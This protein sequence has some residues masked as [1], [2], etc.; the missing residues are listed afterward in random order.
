[1]ARQDINIGVEGN[2]GTGDSIRE[3]FRKT[4]ENFSELYAVFG[5]GG[6]IELTALSD[7]PDS[8]T[9]QAGKIWA[10]KQD[11]T[12]VEV[13]ELASGSELTGD[14][15]DDTVRFN[16]TVPGKLIIETQN[17]K[18]SD[19]QSPTLAQ[20]MN[21]NNKGIA[22]VAITDAAA[23]AANNRYGGNITIDDLVIDKKYGDE[24]YLAR[25]VPG[26]TANLRSEP[27]DG[28]EYDFIIDSFDGSSVNIPA[29]GLNRSS[30]VAPYVY[31]TTGVAAAPLVNEQ[32]YYIRVVNSEKV[33]LYAD[34]ATAI[35]GTAPIVITSE[36]TGQHSL[37]DGA[38]DSALQGYWLK[39]E[40]LPREAVVR[41]QG[42]AM[43]GA[44]QLHDHPGQFA[45]QGI[46]NGLDDFQAASKYYVDAQSYSSTTNLY[47][48]PQGTDRQELIPPDKQGRSPAFAFKTINAACRKAEEIIEASPFEP[49]PY[50]QIITHSDQNFNSEIT[51]AAIDGIL[52]GRENVRD[53]IN[54]NKEFL[55]AEVM[56]FI[57]VNYPD[58][59]YNT[60]LCYRDVGLM[61]DSIVLDV[62]TGNNANYLSRWAGIRYY[63][64]PSAQKAITVQRTETIAA[65]EHLK[66][67]TDSIIKS[68]PI[69][70]LQTKFTQ[71]ADAVTYPVDATAAASVEGKFD[72]I[73]DV[74]NDGVLNAPKIVDG[75]LYKIAITNGNQGFVDQ[76]DP[77]NQDL[78]PGKVIRGRTSGA[79]GRII[80]YTFESDTGTVTPLENDT[81]EVVLLE[82]KTFVEGE[83]L[84]YGNTVRS[85]QVTVMIETGVYYED[86]PIKVPANTTIFGDEFR[87]SIIRPKRRTSQSVW[88][89]LYFYRDKQF[90]GLTGTSDSVTGFPD[91]NLPIAGTPYVNPLTDEVDGYF[92]YHYLVDPTRPANVSSLGANNPGKFPQASD[93]LLENKEF[94]IEEVIQY[95]DATYPTLDYDEQK[96]R[97]DTGLILDAV[98]WD[99]ALGTNYYSVTAGLAYQRAGSAYL[100][101]NQKT[102]T[103]AA[104][105][106]V[107]SQ[108]LGLAEVAND[109][110]ATLR[111]TNGFNEILDILQNGVQSTDTSADALVFPSPVGVAAEK[112]NARDQLQAN[113][114]FLAAE[115]VAFVDANNPPAGIDTT[116]CGRDTKYI[117]DALTTDLL[118]G[119][120]D[121]TIQAARAYIDGTAVVQGTDEVTATVN[122][123][124]HLISVA[125]D[126]IQGIAVTPTTGNTEVQDF[127]S[128]NATN[129][130]AAELSTLVNYVIDV[131]NAGDTSTLPT[132]TYADVTWATQAIQDAQQAIVAARAVIIESTITQINTVITFQYNESKCR[133]DTGFIVDGLAHDLEFGG[134]ELTLQN[135]G[136][137]AAGV[138]P[139]SQVTETES[140]INHIKTIAASVL[141][142]DPLNPFNALGSVPQQFETDLTAEANA[143]SNLN[144]LV[145]CITFAFDAD[146][147]PP[148]YNGAMDV[149]LMGDATRVSNVTVQGH[150]GFMVVLDPEGQILT[151]SPYIQVGSSFS[152]SINRQAFRGGM[153]IDAYTGNVPME[154]YQKGELGGVAN[155]DPFYLFVRSNPNEGLFY[156][157]PQVPA[158]FYIDGRRFQVNMIRNWDPDLGT[159]ELILDR[160]SNDGAGFDGITSASPQTGADLQNPTDA[161]PVTIT[162][163]TAGN[164]SMLGNDFTQVNDLGYGLLAANG[165]LSEMVSMFTYYCWAGFYAYNGAEIRSVTGSCCYGEYGLISEGSDPNEIPD[166][167]NLRD[168]MTQ[169]FKTAEAAVILNYA[170]PVTLDEGEVVTQAI[171]GA[172]GTVAFDTSG[173]RVFL[174]NTSGTFDTTNDISG[175]VT[176]N[177]GAPTTVDFPGYENV[178]EQLSLYV[179][180]LEHEM[181]NRGE[182]DIV[183]PVSGIVGRYEVTNVTKIRDLIVDGHVNVPYTITG[184][185]GQNLDI[186]VKKTKTQGYIVDIINPG[187]GFAVGDTLD[188]DGAELG[189]TSGVHNLQLTVAAITGTGATGGVLEFTL[190]AH[191]IN[192]LPTTPTRD[193]QVYKF[194]FTQG[195][196]GYSED[197]LEENTPSGIIGTVRQNQTFV[198][199][200]IGKPENLVIRPSTAVLFLDDPESTYRSIAFNRTESSG[201]ALADGESLV[202]FD[203]TFDYVR[204]IVDRIRATDT[205]HAGLGTTQGA[206]AGDRVIAIEPITDIPEIARLNSGKYAF[207][208]AGKTHQIDAYTDYGDYGIIEIS[209][210][211]D[212]D[213][214]YPARAEGLGEPV[215]VGVNTITLRAGLQAGVDATITINISTC[216][217]TSHD[218]LDIGTG[219]FNQSNYPNVLLGLPREPQQ[220]NEVEE[221][222][223]GRVFYVST[224]QDGFFRVG[225]FFTVDQGT[226]TVTFSASIAL[227]NL[228]GIGFK[229]GVVVSE[230]S[231]DDGMTNN[232]PDTV[233]VQSA[234]RGY[235]NRRLGFDHAG[236]PVTNRI[237]PG[238]LAANGAIPFSGDLTAAGFTITNVGDP[239]VASDV[240][241]KGYVD[242]LIGASNVIGEQRNTEINNLDSDQLLVTTGK[243]RLF[244]DAAT[245]SGAGV[246]GPGQNFTAT[247]GVAPAEVT[248]GTGTIVDVESTVDL[249]KGSVL[250]ITYTETSTPAGGP[251]EVEDTI[252][253]AGGAVG[254]CVVAPMDEFA[255]GVNTTT[256]DISLTSTR[257]DT[258]TTLEILVKD[259]VLDNANVSPTAAIAQ[260]KLNMNA[261]GAIG[262]ISKADVNWTPAD[263]L[264]S[265]L[266]LAAFDEDDFEVTNGVVT[267]K[268][269]D[270]DFADLPSVSQN[271][272][273]GRT[274]AGT[275]SVTALDLTTSG[276]PNAV[277]YTQTDGSIRVNSVRL[278]GNNDYE[279]LSLVGAE[280]QIKTPGQA[281][282]L[283]ASGSDSTLTV[284]MPGS[285]DIG[286]TG[287]EESDLQNN[288]SFNGESRLAVDWIYSSFI[289]APGEKGVASTGIAIGENTGKSSAGEVAI[290]VAN[291]TTLSSVPATFSVAGI[292][293][294]SDNTYDLGSST[295]KYSSVYSA[296]L[297]TNTL[298][299]GGPDVAGTVEGDWTLTAGSSFQATFA[300]LAEW[301]AADA[302]Y[303]PGT[304][305]VF[306]GS[307]EI[308]VTNT[309]GD[310]RVAG[311]VSTDPAYL[312]NAG[313]ECEHKTALALQGRVPV[314]VVGRVQK[315]DLLVTS[316]IPGYATVNNT[317]TVGTIIGKAVGTK[318][319]LEKGIVEVLVGR[320]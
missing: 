158:P 242:G 235:V 104:I 248:T 108:V 273:F 4:N 98:G 173:K 183:H 96:C 161:N 81:I 164:R 163:Q 155:S 69:V 125:Q 292:I 78:L 157:K 194:N 116:V 99:I 148:K 45:G 20:T 265:D 186:N 315:G 62:Q 295:N 258:E 285:L 200:N 312:M 144:N 130:E 280:L 60:D 195:S 13:L 320:V 149:F 102:A 300:D 221:R 256:S 172:S 222:N 223:K 103:V 234:V 93:L 213:V 100:Q 284:E 72:V 168:T 264:Q 152:Q 192:E 24:N 205:T 227:S 230:F 249:V 171:S 106:Y 28:T 83:E 34:E 228:D 71:I 114:N 38:Y 154:V 126:V 288:S 204:V 147:N 8:Y 124:N 37:T 193:G 286:N 216:R 298:T 317:P 80:R 90:D 165:A 121:A 180:D 237:G 271:K 254:E 150:G 262:P 236:D 201:A 250:I 182:L 44:L 101:A 259:G 279:I 253:V 23:T 146:F 36:G 274:D 132:P 79:L 7:T 137:Y 290:V 296:T 299:T 263:A 30:N 3:S 232:A 135:Q 47:V 220:P 140:A 29:H 88:A 48:N 276:A 287:A 31:R 139:G 18:L 252:S 46:V 241:T 211:A 122:A 247:R 138:L 301:Y 156:K 309:K 289:E 208:W 239:T 160:T 26:K 107:K 260:S 50:M 306:G 123:Y 117:V 39:N 76:G 319:D 84:E 245:V 314:K 240:S 1:M 53:L 219:G 49:G 238:V 73:L 302:D 52:P 185:V 143:L 217:A 270:V 277:V 184:G 177:I 257:T 91:P 293:P 54:L 196:A 105:E 191:T 282:V 85:A 120:N 87:R 283:T 89:D 197:G 68:I 224:D 218:F 127:T 233:P 246:F 294:D 67:I 110:D 266:G 203:A 25:G 202:S 141:A 16:Y 303:E 64:S 77:A 70:P 33:E 113:R 307:E 226:G 316:A 21:A 57:S 244:V 82:P 10:V 267:L 207:T 251:I 261:A 65:I 63:S 269:G 209:D 128:A 131:V 190:G 313:I 167:V 17:T 159:A 112:E 166:A 210:V 119:G 153:Y 42:D 61:L 2:D 145:D 136:A 170:S 86:Y 55:Q 278:G 206:T 162:V 297:Q 308:T 176:G 188:I 318:E 255:N 142:N 19:D 174:A 14:A 43:E 243:K 5:I 40:A 215:V 97:R 199:N 94:I 41:R 187:T 74:I 178:I 111:A 75:A 51:A 92:G 11:E 134:R 6:Q 32:T 268:G 291:G 95:I 35:I 27:I 9:N 311:V 22:N 189:G 56:E 198:L 151:K 118:Y 225:R 133:R 169:S 281:T 115:V 272:V 59:D 12:G 175:S 310:H 304:V 214:V 179:Y 66:A 58:L 231:T 129:I 275:G 109:G 15:L 212:T 229:R 305:V 181:Q